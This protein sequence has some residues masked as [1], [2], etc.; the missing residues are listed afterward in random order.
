MTHDRDELVDTCACCGGELPAPLGP[1]LDTL[2]EY[3]TRDDG[4]CP[5][6]LAVAKTGH[7]LG[8]GAWSAAAY[9]HPR[10]Q[11]EETR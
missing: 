6:H 5:G 8:C 7:V 1:A 4:K 2:D 11:E 3:L 9:T 10:P